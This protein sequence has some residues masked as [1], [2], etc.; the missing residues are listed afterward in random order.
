MNS[1]TFTL[2]RSVFVS[3]ACLALAIVLGYL[4]A[5]P[6]SYTTLTAFT[7]FSLVV[8]FPLVVRWH[9]VL[10]ICSW[11]ALLNTF[12]LPGSPHLWTVMSCLSLFISVLNRAIQGRSDYIHVRSLAVPL[13]LLAVVVLITA[14]LTGGFGGRALGAETWGAKRYLGVL[15][16]IIGYFALTSQRI[17]AEKATVYAGLFFLSG[18][19]AALSN[20]VYAAG[21]QFYFL[22]PFLSTELAV[23]QAMSQDTLL[24]LPGIFLAC[25]SAIYYMLMRYGIK[26]VLDLTRPWRFVLFLALFV[27]S[28]LGGYRSAVLLVLLLFGFQ[29][30]FEGLL[31]TRFLL[32]FLLATVL[33]GAFLATFANKMPLSVQRSL[34]FL[35]IGVDQ[36]VKNDAMS[37]LDWRFQIW[38]VVLPEVPK[39]LIFGKGY[40]YS[41]VDVYLTQEAMRRGLYQSYESTLIDGNYHSGPL[42]LIVPFGLPG[43][44]LTVWFLVFALRVLYC[45]YRYG[46]QPLRLTNT[47]LIAYFLERLVYFVVFYGQFDMDFFVF[48]GTVGLSLAI[49]GGVRQLGEREGPDLLP[50][51]SDAAV[52]A[53]N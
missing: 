39:Y 43:L 6:Y 9:Y 14:K 47:F 21:P 23:G 11:N 2:S 53:A 32:V 34:S 44:L 19:T 31:K 22:F 46:E 12:F 16:A 13:V 18:T 1:G 52:P 40:A 25:M 48:T 45:N 27:F 30:Y 7:L 28:L 4:L 15:G 24:R 20:F 42:T 50:E 8:G 35:P 3:A 10:L 49:N 38:K 29:F 51:A 33:T 26:G 36:Q 5:T 37:T 41:G 17:P